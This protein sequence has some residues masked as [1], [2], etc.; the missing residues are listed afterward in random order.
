MVYCPLLLFKL[1]MDI[2]QSRR[3]LSSLLCLSCR[4][5][6]LSLRSRRSLNTSPSSYASNEYAGTQAF[7]NA[8]RNA[9]RPELPQQQ[10]AAGRPEAGDDAETSPRP[11]RKGSFTLSPSKGLKNIAAIA[12]QEA[13][14]KPDRTVV[15]DSHHLHVY[16]TKHNTHITLTKQNREPLL[17]V[18]AGNLGFRK[19]QRGSFDAAYQLASYTMGKMHEKGLL[20]NM[21]KLEVVMRGFGPGREAFQ[22]ALMGTEGKGIKGKVTR[23]TDSTRL[24]F[25]G[26]RSKNVRRL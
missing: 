4:A 18:S 17:S 20:I 3:L 8:L 7:A 11:Q 26:V 22:K 10:P 1:A 5:R 13:T 24:K 6:L 21:D 19:A 2:K 16:A 25:G 15:S 9:G 23:V 14:S 12:D